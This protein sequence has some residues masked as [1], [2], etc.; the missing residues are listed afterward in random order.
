MGTIEKHYTE[1][2]KHTK[3]E[4]Q[5][6]KIHNI[7]I[8]PAKMRRV[9]EI[10]LKSVYGVY[11]IKPTLWVYNYVPDSH[12]NDIAEVR[13]VPHDLLLMLNGIEDKIATKSDF[14]RYYLLKEYGGLYFDTDGICNKSILP[15]INEY[16]VIVGK[17]CE[18]IPGGNNTNIYNGAVVYTSTPNNNHIINL[19][20]KCIETIIRYNNNPGWGVTGPELI[21]DYIKN[22][23]DVS[24]IYKAPIEAFY[25][26]EWRDGEWQK[27]F[28]NYTEDDLNGI[29]YAHLWGKMSQVVLDVI[30][31]EYII[32]NDNL[33]TAIAKRYL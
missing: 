5:I 25:K 7:W 9:G 33:Y 19:L 4:S 32:K 28:G 11:N 13:D 15:L 24:S 29:Y 8:G 23:S 16:D 12:I 3:Q 18:E 17:W 1:C 30:D 2:V 21:T 20:N 27:W 6:K 31:D 22:N 14:A 10:M 26:Y